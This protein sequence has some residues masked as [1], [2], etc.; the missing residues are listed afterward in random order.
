MT[1]Q[2]I[3]TIANKITEAQFDTL[4]NGFNPEEEKSF[5]TL[6]KL[7]DTKEVA[8]WTVIAERYNSVEVSEMYNQAYNY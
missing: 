7:G 6:V 5:N 1:T 2:E 8:L 4:L 3:Y